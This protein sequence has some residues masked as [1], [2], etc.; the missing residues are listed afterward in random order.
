M[1]SEHETLSYLLLEEIEDEEVPIERLSVEPE[2]ANEHP[3]STTRPEE[4]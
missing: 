1:V 2:N 4:G 3:L